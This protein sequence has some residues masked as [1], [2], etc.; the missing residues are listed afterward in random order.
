MLFYR[1]Y[2]GAH[3]APA[4]RHLLPPA[5]PGGGAFAGPA[6]RPGA[7]RLRRAAAAV[8][9][10][11]GLGRGARGAAPGGAAP[12]RAGH[13]HAPPGFP[14]IRPGPFLFGSAGGL[15]G[16]RAA[17]HAAAGG[18]A[19]PSGGGQPGPG[20]LAQRGPRP[21]PAGGRPRAPAHAVPGGALPGR[22]VRRRAAVP[23]G[24]AAVP[25]RLYLRRAGHGHVP[26]PARRALPPAGAHGGA[27]QR[28]PVLADRPHHA[29]PGRRGAV[30][31]HPGQ[32]NADLPFRAD[33]PAHHD[34]AVP[35]R[36]LPGGQPGG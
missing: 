25:A 29:G 7:G 2:P 6:G 28:V 31:P 21:R 3:H 9:A 22:G 20:R 8:P 33:R 23:H 26:E 27:G 36:G 16:R 34:R 19:G 30:L 13:P 18:A 32:R 11:G 24:L 4:A 10:A 17:R 5:R 14:G 1:H 15:R 12:G 35:E